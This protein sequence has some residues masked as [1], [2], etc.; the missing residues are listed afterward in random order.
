MLT[1]RMMST[2]LNFLE[3]VFQLGFLLTGKGET[4]TVGKHIVQGA[5]AERPHALLR[6]LAEAEIGQ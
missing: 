6:E 5:P 3:D 1:Q 4:I 2:S